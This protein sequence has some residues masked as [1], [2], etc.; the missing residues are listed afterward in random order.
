[1]F[2][3]TILSDILTYSHAL[4]DRMNDRDA[5]FETAVKYFALADEYAP[6]YRKT[7]FQIHWAKM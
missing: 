3:L 7:S 2:Y 5:S 4:I 1:M 6:L